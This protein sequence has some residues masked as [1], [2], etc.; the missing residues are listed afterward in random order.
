[1]EAELD[2]DVILERGTQARLLVYPR[3]HLA[4]QPVERVG[5]DVAGP[6]RG[7]FRQS[8]MTDRRDQPLAGAPGALRVAGP[9]QDLQ[10]RQ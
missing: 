3:R 2:G 10:F 6:L 7:S 4:A 8:P 9:C 5:Q 1:M